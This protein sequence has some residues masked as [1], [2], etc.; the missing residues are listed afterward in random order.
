MKTKHTMIISCVLVLGIILSGL[1]FADGQGKGSRQGSGF[2]KGHKGG[3]LMLLAKYEQTNLAVQVLSDLTGQSTEAIRTKLKEQ[4]MRTVMQELNIDRQAFL[5]AIECLCMG[6]HCGF[7]TA[8]NLDEKTPFSPQSI[9]HRAATIGFVVQGWGTPNSFL[10]RIM[11]LNQQGLFPYDRLIK[12][13]EFS[14]I[15]KAFEE[16]KAGRA[17]K[18][19]L[20]MS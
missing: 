16:S 8:P 19:V 15:N 5:D 20:K 4:R 2:K 13:Y 11:D 10:P 14:D 7:V 3:G 17:I 1:A 9:L 18:P 12:T 6:G